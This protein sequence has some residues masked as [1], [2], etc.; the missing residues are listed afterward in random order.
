MFGYEYEQL[1]VS[2][3]LGQSVLYG[4]SLVTSYGTGMTYDWF[5]PQF[6]EVYSVQQGA[7]Y[8]DQT[9]HIFLESTYYAL[10]SGEAR[11]TIVTESSNLER[12]DVAKAVAG[13]IISQMKKDGTL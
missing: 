12:Q 8:Y 3:E 9:R 6:V 11:W 4:G 1:Q 13:K 10:P 5:A 7:G 2:Q